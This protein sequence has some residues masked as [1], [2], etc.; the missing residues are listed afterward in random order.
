MKVLNARVHGVLDYGVVALFAL[1]PTLFGFE[2][3]PEIACYVVAAVHLV[4]SLL[5]AYPLG[6]LKLIPFPLHGRVEVVVVPSLVA[7]PWLL[8]FSDV[9]AARNFFLAAAALIAVVVILTNYK[10]AAD[11]SSRA[12][13]ARA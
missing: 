1:A 10:S 13:P 6:I 7:L 4:M 11:S 5:T 8:G 12:V 3:T 2:G 9:L